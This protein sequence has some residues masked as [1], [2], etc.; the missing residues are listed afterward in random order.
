MAFAIDR[1]TRSTLAF[2]SGAIT[3]TD[4]S[5][6]NG[7]TVFTYASADDSAATIAAANYFNPES[8]I[9]DLAVDDIIMG[10]G[11]DA[12]FALVVATID[13][14]ASPRTITTVSMGLTGSVDTANIAD[15]A[16]TNVKVDAAAAIAF[17]KLEVM[18][19]GNVLV[20]SAG[21]VATEVTMSG[22]VTIV[23]DGT[24]AIGAGKVLSSMVSPLVMQYAAVAVSASAFNGAYATP[25][26]LVAAGGA[27]TLITLHRAELLMTYGA[28]QYANGGAV[29]IQYDSTANGAGVIASTTQAAADFFDAASTANAFEGGVV[30][31]PFTTCVNKGLYLSNITGAFDTGDSDMV[32]HVW[33]S[34]IPT[35]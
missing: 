34:V 21:N 23:A 30:K 6:V 13:T 25:L 19:S 29:S 15:G 27:D 14:T 35:V 32:M 16:I 9:F 12:S 2:N 28:A 5:V 1:F 31:Q 20:G 10:T 4:A 24:T 11:S 26:V 7:P 33:Y 18:T 17:S 3:L 8:V 22:D